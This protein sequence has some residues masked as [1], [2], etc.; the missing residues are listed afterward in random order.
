MNSFTQLEKDLF[1]LK[2]TLTHSDSPF[3]KDRKHHFT[4]YPI[5]IPWRNP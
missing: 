4:P 3:A 1:S 5:T 2:K